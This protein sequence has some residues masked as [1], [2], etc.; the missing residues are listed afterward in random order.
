MNSRRAALEA[1]EMRRVLSGLYQELF[2]PLL[3]SLGLTQME[4]DI[5][6]FLAN[7]PKHDTAAEIVSVRHLTK[8]HVSTSVESLAEK[9]LL[10]RV[11][12]DGDRKRIHLKLRPSA[13]QI[14]EEGRK[15]QDQFVA[16]LT[17]G[18]PEEELR[19]AGKVMDAMLANIRKWEKES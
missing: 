6:L 11:H 7:N 2:R 1:L 8:S 4:A 19:S 17:E 9:D 10:D 15:I 13:G 18:I 3:K 5:L 16:I 14:V 12:E